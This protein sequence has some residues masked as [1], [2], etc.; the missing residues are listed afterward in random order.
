MNAN[1]LGIL[2]LMSHIIN[3]EHDTSDYVITQ[4]I[5][6]HLK[7][8]DDISINDLVDTVHVS[9]SSVRRYA[10]RLGY[11]N[12]SEF[13]S[14]FSDIAFPS[15]IHLRDFYGFDEY[16]SLL[17]QQL[18]D[19]LSDNSRLLSKE[20]IDNFCDEI[21]NH[22]RVYFVCA[23]NTA[24]TMDK[25]QQELMYAH[26]LVEVVSSKFHEGINLRYEEDSNLFVVVSIS[27]VFSTSIDQQMKAQK[28]K[29]IL[30]TVNR[31]EVFKETYDEILYLS[32]NDVVEDKL[33]LL[34]K[35]GVTYFFD[36]VSQHYI[37]KTFKENP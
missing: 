5:L 15:N 3:E 9:R 26:K 35:Y 34:G 13:K 8:L 7:E 12:F 16:K 23:N 4:Y 32:E 10:L 2:N 36:L 1:I 30:I 19:L 25:F 18:A 20:V 24:S 22:N 11:E 21:R 37:Y 28:G 31:S 17:D 33:G 27:G 29:K 6:T 14:S